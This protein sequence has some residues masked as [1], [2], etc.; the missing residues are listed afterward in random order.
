MYVRSLLLAATL[1]VAPL[2]AAHAIDQSS[3]PPARAPA[4]YAPP[5]GAAYSWAGFYG[6]AHVGGAFGRTSWTDPFSGVSDNPSIAGTVGGAQFGYNFQVNAI[7]FG[8]EADFSGA[9]IYGN[10]TDN[11]GFSHSFNSYWTSTVTGK[12]GYA[13]NRVLLY[14]KAGVAFA[15]EADTVTDPFGN[16]ATSS[17]VLRTGWTVGT[18]FEYAWDRKWS[19]RLEYDYMGLGSQSV[20][21]TGP[22]L[23]SLSAPLGVNIQR[24]IGGINYHF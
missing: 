1:C 20:T 6:G 4:A 11:A 7:V 22:L 5:P 12:L 9:S 13:I 19:V 17:A 21:F 10:G 8:A 18:G 24:V 16:T 3:S 23:G 2:A 15:S 14:G